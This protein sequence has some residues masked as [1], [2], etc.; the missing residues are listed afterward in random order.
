MADCQNTATDCSTKWF[1]FNHIG[2]W[3]ALDEEG[4][5]VLAPMTR[6][7]TMDEENLVDPDWGRLSLEEVRELRVIANTLT[8]W[9][10]HY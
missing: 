4:D 1:P 7:G 2:H 3:A 10:R 5:L 9:N 8:A 6:A